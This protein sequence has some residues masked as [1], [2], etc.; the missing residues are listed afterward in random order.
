MQDEL[1]RMAKGIGEMYAAAVTDHAEAGP[2]EIGL[3]GVHIK[4]WRK[5]YAEGCKDMAE[6][7]GSFVP[8]SDQA[9]FKIAVLESF[10]AHVRA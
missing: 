9:M 7:V 1:E 8:I 2:E 4:T 6:K 10:K 3:E 5:A